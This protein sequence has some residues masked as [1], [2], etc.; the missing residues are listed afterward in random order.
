M[1]NKHKWLVIASLI[2]IS[3]FYI[4]LLSSPKNLITAD[5]GRHIKNGELFLQNGIIAN[6][7]L[8]SYT[9]PNFPFINHHWGTGVIFYLIYQ[10]SGWMGLLWTFIVLSLITFYIFFQIA[11]K[12]A[13]LFIPVLIALLIMP[14]LGNRTEIRPEVFSYLFI[15]IFFLI[16]YKFQYQKLQP[17]YLWI[18]PFLSLIWVNLHIYFIFGLVLIGI[19]F[20]ENLIVSLFKKNNFDKLLKITAI[21]FICLLVSFFNPS[22]IEGVIYPSKIFQNY[23]Y[24]ILENKSVFYVENITSYP[25]AIY[26]K[27]VLSLVVISWLIFIW[28]FLNKREKEI[29][30]SL[31]LISLIFGYLGYSAVRNMSIFGLFALVIISFN[32]Q[33]VSRFLSLKSDTTKIYT[34]FSV[35]IIILGVLFYLNPAYW[36]GRQMYSF[37]VY[38]TQKDGVD[39]IQE[40]GLNGPIFN[41][42]DIGGY[43]IFRMYPEEK[44]FVDNRPEAYPADFFEQTYK[45]MQS[46]SQKFKEISEIY[47]FNLIYFYRYDLTEWAQKFLVD[48]ISDPDWIPVY[49]DEATILFVKNDPKNKSVIDNYRLPKELFSVT[50]SE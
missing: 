2:I 50:T 25:P 6:T 33:F 32:L 20:I 15:A 9:H 48:R 43:L 21:G 46:N 13:G 10:I 49:V 31:I 14:L 11:Y 29:K 41:N 30:I 45:P 47:K 37:S 5:L 3:F 40:T 8:Y 7:N 42:Y 44:V 27:L 17:R 24:Q 38:P 4:G 36:E 12:K 23:G 18:L 39:F 16:L 1:W 22:G 26:L 28:R 34:Y 19:F 35:G